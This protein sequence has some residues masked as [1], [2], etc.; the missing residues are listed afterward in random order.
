MQKRLQV[1]GEH[2]LRYC[3][4][5]SLDCLLEA[6]EGILQ[7]LRSR[8]CLAFEAVCDSIQ[9][10]REVFVELLL[11]DVHTLMQFETGQL[12]AIFLQGNAGYEEQSQLRLPAGDSAS[13]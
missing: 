13:E 11:G 4:L 5:G 8:A 9:C 10:Y 2:S 12:Q 6:H 7:A 3:R 1:G